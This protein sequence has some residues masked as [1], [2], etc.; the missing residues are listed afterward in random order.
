M[1]HLE[2]EFSEIHCVCE[3]HTQENYLKTVDYT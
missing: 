2:I 3:L 1:R